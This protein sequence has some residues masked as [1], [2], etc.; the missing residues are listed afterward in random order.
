MTFLDDS[1]EEDHPDLPPRFD[2]WLAERQVFSAAA[3]L[4]ALEEA[5]VD[6]EAVR[7]AHLRYRT[8]WLRFMVSLCNLPLADRPEAVEHVMEA[9]RE[10]HLL[11]PQGSDAGPGDADDPSRPIDVPP[12]VSH[13]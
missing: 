7:A 11:R 4:R 1:D 9:L 10:A 3:A 13:E 8:A 6:P 12:E 2:V 5:E